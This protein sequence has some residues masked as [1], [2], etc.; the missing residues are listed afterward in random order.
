MA[1]QPE[2]W[3]GHTM[4]GGL[5]SLG[6]G[7]T[8]ERWRGACGCPARG[9]DSHTR[10]IATRSPRL[11]PRAPAPAEGPLLAPELAAPSVSVS[12]SLNRPSVVTGMIHERGAHNEAGALQDSMRP[13][14]LARSATLTG[15]PGQT[16]QAS[17]ARRAR[18]AGGPRAWA[19]GTRLTQA[20]PLA[21]APDNPS[22]SHRCC[23]GCFPSPAQENGHLLVCQGH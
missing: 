2:G 4:G 11:A 1:V 13:A 7:H 22:A 10:W 15:D 12:C 9:L 20:G 19:L 23:C 17:A 8:H 3:T 5:H 18:R 21:R 14:Q 16:L 6:L